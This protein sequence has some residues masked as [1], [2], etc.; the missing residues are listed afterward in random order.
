MQVKTEKQQFYRREKRIST[1]N[2]LIE[3]ALARKGLFYPFNLQWG[4]GLYPINF[5]LFKMGK[6]AH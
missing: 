6:V 1:G 3:A 5:T 2:L 4:N